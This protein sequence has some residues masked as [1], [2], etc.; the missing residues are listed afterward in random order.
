MCFV[1]VAIFNFNLLVSEPTTPPTTTQPKIKPVEGDAKGQTSFLPL[2]VGAIGACALLFL[3][4]I[5]VFI[6]LKRKCDMVNTQREGKLRKSR[7]NSFSH[8][9]NYHF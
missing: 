1:L 7:S 8:I 6:A 4:F 2:I 9:S 5:L 3:I